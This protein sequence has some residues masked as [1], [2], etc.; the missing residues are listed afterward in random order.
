M[1]AMGT[2]SE[3]GAAAGRAAKGAARRVIDGLLLF[4]SVAI[5]A[6]WAWQGVYQ[7][8]PE[9]SAVILRLGAYDR[10]HSVPGYWVHLP[11]PLETHVVVNTRELRTESF[12]ESPTRS[13]PGEPSDVEEGQVAAEIRREAIQTADHNVLHVTYE[14]QYKIADGHA[15]VF[16]M[17]DPAAV[18]HDATEAAMR[19]VIGKSGIDAVL[20]QDQSGVTDEAARLLT[21]MLADYASAV[22]QAPAFEVSRINLEK[23]QAP[24]PVRE[25]FVDVVS[26]GQDEKRSSLEAQ[27]DAAEIL[28]RARSEAAEIHEQAEAYRAAK[29]VE[30]QGDATRFESLLVEYQAAPEVTR[31]RLYLETM[32]SVLPGMEKAIVD[33]DAVHLWSTWPP[34]RGGAEPNAAADEGEKKGKGKR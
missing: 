4:V 31:K 2:G 15:W 5:L 21:R 32:E 6:G 13:T 23:P 24:E 19:N 12:G 18:L 7:L 16:S 26:A 22:G 27:G 17:A 30:A 20:S 25:A 10:T 8:A 29:I 3:G 9:E 28:E 14:L 1:A 11:P 33:R 34:S